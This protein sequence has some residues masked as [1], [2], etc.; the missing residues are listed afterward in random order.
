[1]TSAGDGDLD[2]LEDLLGPDVEAAS[3][4]EGGVVFKCHG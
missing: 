4:W 3:R 1:M 2:D